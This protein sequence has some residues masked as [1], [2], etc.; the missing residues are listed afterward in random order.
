MGSAIHWPGFVGREER[1]AARQTADWSI[2][3]AVERQTMKVT[4]GMD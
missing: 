1:A 4:A 3:N 2:L